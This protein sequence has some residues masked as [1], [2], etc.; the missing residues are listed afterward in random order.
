MKFINKPIVMLVAAVLL[1]ATFFVTFYATSQTSEVSQTQEEAE[2]INSIAEIINKGEATVGVPPQSEPPLANN[3]NSPTNYT[4]DVVQEDKIVDSSGNEYPI[5]QYKVLLTPDDPNATQWWTT[6]TGL[7]QAWGIGSGSTPVTIAIVDTG[8]DLG[9]EEFSGRWYQ[10]S[11]EVGTTST[12]APSDLNC[13]DQSLSLDASCNNIDDDFNGVVDDESGFTSLENPSRLNCSD[14]SK[15]LDKSCNLTDD[16]GNGLADDVTGWDFVN[17]DNVVEAGETNP[18][19]SGTRHGTEVTGVAAA[20]GN[21]GVGIAGVNWGAKILPIQ[22]LDD[23]SYGDTLTVSR[24]VRYAADQGTDVISISLGSTFYDNYLR[25]AIDYAIASGSVVVAA[26]GNDGCDCIQYPANFP[27]VVAVGATD[28]SGARASFSNWGSNID[29]V[30]PGVN[31]RTT[32]WDA[33]SDSQYVTSVN[34]TS[35]STP[36]VSGL[37][38][39]MRS[40]Q[41]D[42]T[43]GELVATLSAE[44]DHS[45]LGAGENFSTIYGFGDASAGQAMSRV[46]TPRTD[47]QEYR[48]TPFTVSDVLDSTLVYQCSGT[49]WPSA[50]IYRLK[51]ANQIRY[52]VSEYQRYQLELSSWVSSFIGYSCGGLPTDSPSNV[53]QINLLREIE[54]SSLKSL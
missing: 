15:T 53:R 31:I 22:A 5:R 23:D 24:A 49:D 7:E 21:N 34:G 36:F 13:S 12:E 25:Q 47:L 4:Q 32:V 3:T 27:E 19:G 54:N 41:P 8:F 11:G 29:I 38:A 2:V 14:Q 52:S 48:F 10:N 43:W 16:D 30:A 1:L 50:R 26:T 18:L 40:Q 46:V 9:H 45:Q 42:A 37:L 35:F 20:T 44:A 17:F 33:S 28:S 51:K 39:M 6:S